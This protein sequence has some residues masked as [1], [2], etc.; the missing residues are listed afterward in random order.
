MPIKNRH[1]LRA[2]QATAIAS[3]NNS[4]S[5]SVQ[6]ADALVVYLTASAGTVTA[7][8]QGSSDGGTNWFNLETY[9]PSGA[10]NFA[11]RAIF[12]VPGLCRIAVGGT[13]NITNLTVEVC[14]S[15]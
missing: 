12:P 7:T 1:N 2:I 3:G 11:Y 6:E 5:F 14:R 13:G 8:L 4:P 9:S 15:I 10:D